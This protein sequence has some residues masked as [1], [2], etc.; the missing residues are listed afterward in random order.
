MPIMYSELILKSDIDIIVGKG[1]IGT[2]VF[3]ILVLFKPKVIKQVR[4]K[5]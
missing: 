5:D 4:K 3:K 2:K 1:F